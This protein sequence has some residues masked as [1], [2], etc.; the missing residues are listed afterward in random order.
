MQRF[1][2]LLLSSACNEP[3]PFLLFTCPV[4]NWAWGH[5]L[6]S[7]PKG[8]PKP[9]DAML[10][11]NPGGR[12]AVKNCSSGTGWAL[13]YWA[14]VFIC[15]IRVFFGFSSLSVNFLLIIFFLLLLQLFNFNYLTVL[16]STHKFF[17][18]YL[19]NSLAIPLGVGT[20]QA[21]VL[22]LSYLWLNQ[23]TTGKITWWL[24]HPVSLTSS[25]FE[26]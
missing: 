18:F 13:V 16:M 15:I 20:E 1:F 4:S 3:R 12:L 17:H 11:S 5:S 2:Q 8:Y 10:S 22:G 9:Y 25:I 24:S 21:A 26:G 19:Y 14:I 6:D 23:N 7:R